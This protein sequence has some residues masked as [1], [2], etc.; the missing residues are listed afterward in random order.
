[1]MPD[2][3][4]DY[5]WLTSAAAKPV[6]DTAL[7][8]LREKQNILK[9][10]QRI[11]K[12]G[13]T[14]KQAALVLE[15]VQ[16]RHRARQKFSNA[17]QLFFTRR[18]YEQSTGELIARYKAI[19]FSQIDRVADI[20]C[21][22]GG[23]LMSLGQR[24]AAELT[25]GCDYDLLCCR[26]ATMNAAVCGLQNVDVR[27]SNFHEVDFREF[28]AIHVDP[29][30]RTKRRTVAGQF[31]DPALESAIERL[32]PVQGWAIKV[33]PATLE[34]PFFPADA[35]LE[36]IGDS[37]ECKQQ[38]IWHG[39]TAAKPG[40]RTATRVKKHGDFEQFSVARDD[41]FPTVVVAREIGRYLYEPHPSVLAAK[42]TD[43]LATEFQ[44]ARLSPDIPYLTSNQFLKVPLTAVY[45]I[46]NVL[47]FSIRHV[48][49]ELRRLEVGTIDIKKRGIV[50]N[51]SEQFEKL[52]LMGD[53][54]AT[55]VLT[56]HQRK[57][58]VLFVR[59]IK[60]SLT[61]V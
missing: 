55:L 20:C 29:D 3:I 6:L 40:F 44:L 59:R 21:G 36:W 54:K 23:D 14:P 15:L 30:R 57:R 19:R 42:L 48:G 17:D 41:F 52:K 18:G 61:S 33:A 2:T 49:T 34:E 58:I 10:A 5:V 43:F 24:E 32:A 11:R 8:E 53:Q 39:S 4:D 51:D 47:P 28:S 38:M 16:L 56:R 45:Q 13:A 25:V 1:M 46:E 22:I 31:F 37:R 50:K 9:I 26:Y 12:R 7:Q 27:L 35:E 60:K